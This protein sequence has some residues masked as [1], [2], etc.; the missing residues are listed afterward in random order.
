MIKICQGLH[1]YW[2]CIDFLSSLIYNT[3]WSTEK[4]I[5]QGFT[6]FNVLL[7]LKNTTHTLGKKKSPGRYFHIRRLGRLG[8]GLKFGDK[9]GARSPNKKKN[10]RSSGSILVH[11]PPG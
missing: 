4:D 1:V 10:L 11:L 9:F 6:E 8:P 2:L 5:W 3:Y 7:Q